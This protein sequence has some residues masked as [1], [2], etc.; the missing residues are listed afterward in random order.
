EPPRSAP[1]SS[2]LTPLGSEP[3][4]PSGFGELGLP[5]RPVGDEVGEEGD[6]VP[7]GRIAGG[8]P[9]EDID[10]GDR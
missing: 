7:Q 9:R 5:A 6:E 2:P 1:D 3:L 10:G 8:V 4:D